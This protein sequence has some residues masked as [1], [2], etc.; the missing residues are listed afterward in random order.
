M[1]SIYNKC[2]QLKIK[3]DT[4]ND[5]F[6]IKL[7]YKVFQHSTVGKLIF[8]LLVK[9]I[10]HWKIIFPKEVQFSIYCQHAMK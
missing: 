10:F 9:M 5:T 2:Q 7:K 8:L 6:I 4:K 3:S 1:S